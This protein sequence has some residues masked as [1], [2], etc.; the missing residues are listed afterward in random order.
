MTDLKTLRDL[1]MNPVLNME[2]IIADLSSIHLKQ[3]AIKEIK[4]FREDVEKTKEGI[5]KAFISGKINYI[6]EKNNITEDDLK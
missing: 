4:Q 3:E 5:E 6:K 2:G 1:E